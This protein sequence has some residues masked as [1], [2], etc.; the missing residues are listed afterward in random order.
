M[1]FLGIEGE[2]MKP[3][4]GARQDA[5]RVLEETSRT[6]YIPIL[7]LNAGLQE[8][9]ASAYLCMRA[10]DEIE[11][12]PELPSS[13]KARLL[14]SIGTILAEPDRNLKLNSLLQEHAADLPEVTL[15]LPDWVDLC[16]PEA[17]SRMLESLREM[18]ERMA[19]W[20]RKEW[21]V[22]TEEDL[23][24]Y[25]YSV[26]GL[27]GIML[28]DLWKWDSGISVDYGQA[29][30]FGRGLQSVN[31]IRNRAED[32]TRGVCFFPQDWEMEQMLAYSKR[33]LQQAALYTQSL[34]QGPIYEFCS[35]PLALA[36]A[37]LEAVEAGQEKLSRSAVLHL[38]QQIV[39]G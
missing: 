38:V 4:T 12:H 36:Q 11:D 8:A 2:S 5:M 23:D 1:N 33:N 30:A 37:T 10:I 15:R 29:V 31:I 18:A 13:V 39:G 16:P 7:R 3:N 24:D 17:V 6:F 32:H 22:R 19:V 28:T 35:I 14:E 34:P 21:V 25:T 27:V 9:V 26:A 20:V